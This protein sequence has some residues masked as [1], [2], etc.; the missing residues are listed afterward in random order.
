VEPRAAH[1][2]F[3]S[4][5]AQQPLNRRLRDI[6]EGA[7]E[8]PEAIASELQSLRKAIES[9][10]PEVAPDS[11]TAADLARLLRTDQRTLRAMR[12]ADEVPRG[13]MCGR[14]ALWR[15]AQIEAWLAKAQQ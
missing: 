2:I 3:R 10:S 6:D 9:R 13:F 14:S 1:A 5:T 7:V 8:L 12:Q 15:R 11:L 4:V